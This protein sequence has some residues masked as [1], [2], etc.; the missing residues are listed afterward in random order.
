MPAVKSD[1]KD[2]QLTELEST[3]AKLQNLLVEKGVLSSEDIAMKSTNVS[4]SSARLEQNAPN[5]FSTTTTIK[6][7]VPDNT[8]AAEI[9]IA[10]QTGKVMRTISLN[11][12]GAG[13]I[14][15]NAFELSA[16][17]YP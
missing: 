4:L 14:V 11:Q 2:K 15:I 1:A 7:F 16:G 12:R 17:T 3:V 8:G 13:Q 9:T 6:Y 10:D 5:P